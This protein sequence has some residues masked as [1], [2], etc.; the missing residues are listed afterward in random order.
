MKPKAVF[1]LLS[2]L[3]LYKCVIIFAA[4]HGASFIC[5]YIA[6][7]ILNH[8]AYSYYEVAM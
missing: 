3:K 5:I 2:L 4:Q 6:S 7:C 8:S 1:Q